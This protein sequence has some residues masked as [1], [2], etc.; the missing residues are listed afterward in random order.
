LANAVVGYG[1]PVPTYYRASDDVPAGVDINNTAYWTPTTLGG[2]STMADLPLIQAQTTPVDSSVTNYVTTTMATG[3]GPNG[4]ITT[5]D[6]LGLAL[7]SNNF[8]AQLTTATAAINS[9]QGAGSLATLNTA[10]VNILSAINTA[11][12]VT[13]IGNANSA[14]A[15][16]TGNPSVTTLNTAWTYMA[17]LMNLSARYTDQAGINY[18]LLQ[19]GD[20]NSVYAFVQ[21][22]PGYGLLT[23]AG[24]AAEFLENIA[25]TTTLG[26]QAIV[27]VMREGRNNARLSAAGLYNTNQIPSNPEIAPIPVVT[28][29]T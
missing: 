20:K 26:G 21:N 12:V 25:D 5:Y 19:S 1:S 27:G 7:D 3:T 9:L 23:A 14:I 28:P 6:I 22:L 10:Y 18:F 13:Q 29:V 24:D 11:G 17:N 16:L 4:T 2:L 8:A 15:A